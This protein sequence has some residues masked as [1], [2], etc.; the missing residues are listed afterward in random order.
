MQNM[1]KALSVFCAVLLLLI[2][3]VPAFAGTNVD[4]LTDSM[5]K[6]IATLVLSSVEAGNDCGTI[7]GRTN[8]KNDVLNGISD[9]TPYEQAYAESAESIGVTV[10]LAVEAVKA[11][12]GIS[13]NDAKM[14]AAA[15]TAAIKNEI[16]PEETTTSSSSD[17]TSPDPS[18]A[19]EY[20]VNLL[21]NL[22]YDQI[23]STIVT[24]VG[25]EVITADEANSVIAALY[26]NGSITAEERDSLYEAVQSDEASTNAVQNFFKDYTAT[27]LAQL[28]R[29]FGDSISQMTTALANLFRSDSDDGDGTSTTGSGSSSGS[30][31]GTT[32]IPATGDYAI[33]AVAAVALAAGAALILTRKKKDDKDD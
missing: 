11:D 17:T 26:K 31:S 22:S 12:A 30:S 9:M 6:E 5:Q 32:D 4:A 16:D 33:P 20:I 2:T 23:E 7:G 18:N 15:I 29:G 27:D 24:L 1:K 28:F 21:S 25:N 13:D 10:T 3:C 14:L 19:P 8:I